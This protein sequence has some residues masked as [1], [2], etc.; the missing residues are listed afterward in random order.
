M[1]G[2]ALALARM[3]FKLRTSPWMSL[4]LGAFWT[5]NLISA[6]MLAAGIARNYQQSATLTQEIDLSAIRQDT[7]RVDAWTTAFDDYHKGP[8]M[9]K[10]DDIRISDQ[11]M[12]LNGLVT[13]N[14]YQSR[15]G[16]FECAKSI[17][18]RGHN[19]TIAGEYARQTDFNVSTE[20]GILRIPT[21]FTI[22]KG[23]KFHAQNVRI[24]IGIPVGKHVVFG[25]KIKYR[26]RDVD[27]GNIDDDQEI[28][29]NPER[30]YQMTENGLQCVACPKLGDK[31]YKPNRYQLFEDFIIHGNFKT[32]IRQAEHFS[33]R[34]EPDNGLSDAIEVLRTGRTLTFT[35]KG[36]PLDN[37]VTV[38][39]ETPT[40]TSLFADECGEIILR[41][42]DE[43][44]A[45][46]SA[47]N[48]KP[49]RAMMDVEN[50][51]INLV[52]NSSLEL[53][54]RGERMEA[55]LI[56]GA[57]LEAVNWL[58]DYADITAKDGA[59]ARINA[60]EDADVK[61]DPESQVELTGR[62]AR[63]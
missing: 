43:G 42:F 49:I 45:S 34:I 36:M 26:I 13:I 9:F 55:N 52:G 4:S 41:G 10:G 12:E 24:S 62:S 48:S 30:L 47:K 32:E 5:L 37:N 20:G 22:P 38:Y 53:I 39:I 18:A 1:F 28:P 58:V 46:I 50:L 17:T 16:N 23:N 19:H 63:E 6:F 15:S 44:Q 56:T 54:G 14:V 40:F 61:S 7:L 25:E 3:V 21:Y 57:N 27:Y 59:R 2:L 11:G 60:R 29:Q 35:S 31:R 8:W 51:K 33:Y